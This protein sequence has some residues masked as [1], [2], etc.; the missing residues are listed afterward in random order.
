MATVDPLYAQWLQKQ[1]DEVVRIDAAAARWGATAQSTERLTPIAT[2]AAA[3]AEADR[4]L[5]FF[6][7]G[8]FGIDVH[9]LAGTDWIN[10]IGTVITLVGPDLGYDDGVDVFVIEAEPDP[11][12]GISNV[13]VIRPLRRFS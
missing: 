7:R 3:L 11:T 13:T 4:E 5:A 6:S 1:S 9:Q 10:A 12:T 8:P 2:R